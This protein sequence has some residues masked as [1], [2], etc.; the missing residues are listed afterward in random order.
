MKIRNKKATFNYT[1]IDK[2]IAGIE[3]KGT[4]VKSIRDLS[5]T[6]TDTFCHITNG[7]MYVKNLVIPRYKNA[8]LSVFHEEN[9]DK[10]LLLK[11][12]ELKKIKKQIKDVGKTI[13]VL[14]ILTVGNRIKLKI[15]TA[16]GK[17]AS[18]KRYS[19]KKRDIDMDMKRGL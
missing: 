5:V 7:E 18:D 12:D 3:L 9:R 15:A 11:K 16:K 2:Y 8:H 17:N 14:E 6:L 10:K 1:I 4:E 19:I 13:I